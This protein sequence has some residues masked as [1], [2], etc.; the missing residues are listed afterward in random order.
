M[1]G[2]PQK[3]LLRISLLLALFAIAASATILLIQRWRG[4][5]T[6]GISQFGR[7]LDDIPGLSQGE[8]VT[9][10][11]LPSLQNDYV[12]L[13]KV[14]QEYIVCALVWTECSGCKEDQPFWKDLNKELRENSVAFYLIFLDNDQSRVESFVNAYDLKDLTVL[15]DQRG[16]A[17]TSF[18]VQI[19]PQYVLVTSSGRVMGRWNGIRRYDPKKQNAIDKL[20]GLR[21][22]ISA[23]SALVIDGRVRAK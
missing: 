9:L 18:K 20:N 22:R 13:T 5:E 23:A 4:G 21:E 11:T 14:E 6:K 19:V 10:P 2:H 8:Q 12:N 1:T 16:Q 17:I 15:C 3:T 7:S